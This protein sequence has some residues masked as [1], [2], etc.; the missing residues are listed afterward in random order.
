MQKTEKMEGPK[1]GK[2]NKTKKGGG[3]VGVSGGYIGVNK[4]VKFKYWRKET[5]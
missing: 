5:G 4:H 2:K 1:L 3:G